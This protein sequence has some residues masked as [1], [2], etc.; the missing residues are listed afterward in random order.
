MGASGMENSGRVEPAV[1]AAVALGRT[2]RSGLVAR[3]VLVVCISVVACAGLLVMRGSDQVALVMWPFFA[4]G[5][6]AFV[7]RRSD[8][9]RLGELAHQWRMSR[10]LPAVLESRESPTNTVGGA[11]A[12][13]WICP[14]D[15]YRQARRDQRRSGSRTN[16][17]P[18]PFRLVIAFVQPDGVSKRL[19]FR[20]GRVVQLHTS[21]ATHERDCRLLASLERGNLVGAFE[22]LGLCLESLVENL[23]LAD[24]RFSEICSRAPSTEHGSL[25]FAAAVARWWGLIHTDPPPRHGLIQLCHAMAGTEQPVHHAVEGTTMHLAA[26]GKL[27]HEASPRFQAEVERKKQVSNRQRPGH[28]INIDSFTGTFNLAGGDIRGRQKNSAISRP[29]P[30]DADLLKAMSTLLNL[31]DI[32]W[33]DPALAAVRLTL[34]D[35][36]SRQDPHDAKVKRAVVKLKEVCS[37]T[38][39]GVLGN[40]AYQ[41]LVNYFS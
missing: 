15:E 16:A 40:A 11:R 25:A 4:V 14:R 32:P 5:A 10:R 24:Q 20:D 21:S 2:E 39:V 28:S 17:I 23:Y 6:T 37:D 7:W 29:T 33:R 13:H 18:V 27:W 34:E 22:N 38:A 26:T 41:L 30:S 1:L 3:V 9:V 12:G 31:A 36:V 35:A 19:A 8:G